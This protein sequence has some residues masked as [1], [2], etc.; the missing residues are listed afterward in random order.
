M[1]KRGDIGFLGDKGQE[2]DLLKAAD[3]AFSVVEKLQPACIGETGDQRKRAWA[4]LIRAV[5]PLLNAD[6]LDS[7]TAVLDRSLIIYR[8]SPY[9]PYFAGQIAYKKNDYAKA[10]AE[11]EN[12]VKIATPLLASDSNLAGITEYSSFFAPYA[13]A[14]GAATLNGPEQAAAFKRVATLYTSYLKDYPCAQYAENAVNGLFDALEATGD[15]AGVRA[16]LTRMV[17]ETKPCS[18]IWWYSAAREASEQNMMELAVQL[19][20][21]AV[22]YSPWSAGLGN[23]GGAFYKAKEGAK[24]LPVAK[25]LVEVAPNL[26]DNYELEASAYQQLSEKA[27]APAA[28][29]AYKDSLVEIYTKG[30]KVQVKVRVSK[31]TSEKDKRTIGGTIELVQELGTPAKKGAK[32][33]KPVA[34]VPAGPK[35]KERKVTLKVDFLDRA[36]AVVTSQ[37]QEYTVKPDEPTNFDLSA[38]DPKIIGY[39]Y[40]PIP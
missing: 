5:G 33:A 8:D 2:I 28:K 26:P 34:A 11:F 20:D 13:G 4:P 36:G 18:D 6:K 21:K 3:S 32:G 15:T 19:A 23:A 31:F 12:A 39:K 7:A 1:V 29:Q 14:R 27:T 22:A 25:R 30:T 37:S 10:T 35:P 24:L 40:A 16:Q 9:S 38:T 17:A